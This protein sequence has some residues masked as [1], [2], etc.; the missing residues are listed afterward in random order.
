MNLLLRMSRKV[1]RSPP[2]NQM[3]RMMNLLLRMPRRVVRT[4]RR[5]LRSPLQLIQKKNLMSLQRRMPRK[6]VRSP[7]RQSLKMMTMRRI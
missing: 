3:M 4:L 2:L 5:V 7:F 6:V 1:V